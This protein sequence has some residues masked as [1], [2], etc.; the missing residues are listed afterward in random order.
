VFV[1]ITE[2]TR[3]GERTWPRALGDGPLVPGPPAPPAP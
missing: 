2:M 1:V 3:R